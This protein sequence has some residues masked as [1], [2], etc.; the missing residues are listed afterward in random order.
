MAGSDRRP[1]SGTDPAEDPRA[2]YDYVEGEVDRPGLVSDLAERVDGDV[3][4]DEY[5]RQLYA[6]DASAYEVTPIGVVFPRSRDDVAAVMA[7]CADRS[8]PVLPRGGGTSLAGQSVNE[9]VVLD[10]TRYMDT[11]LDVDPEGRTARVQP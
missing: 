6:T 11:I 2:T 10:F 8:I 1:G 7:Y 3:R 9:A 5:S 4:F